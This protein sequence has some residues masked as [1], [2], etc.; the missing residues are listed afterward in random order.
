MEVFKD[1]EEIELKDGHKIEIHLGNFIEGEKLFTEVAK[2]YQDGVEGVALLTKNE[3]KLALVPLIKKTFF[4]KEPIKD[5]SFF[6]D[7]NKRQYYVPICMN[8]IEVNVKP[9]MTSPL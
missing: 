7:V 9:F 3:I 5:L 2:C 1:V 4:D 6:E 8:V